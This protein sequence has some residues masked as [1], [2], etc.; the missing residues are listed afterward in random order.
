M[1]KHWIKRVNDY[2]IGNSQRIRQKYLSFLV[3]PLKAI[4]VKANH[5]T[6]LVFVTGLIAVWFAFDNHK[7]FILFGV[8]HILFDLLDGVLARATKPTINGH[9]LDQI[10]DHSIATLL[11]AKTFLVGDALAGI[12]TV[13]YAAHVSIYFIKRCKGPVIFMRGVLF[14]FYFVGYIKAGVILVA[15]TTMFG[16]IQQIYHFTFFKPKR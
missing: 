11:L 9:Y 8:L 5:I 3:S 7:Y 4:G 14:A 13:L 10:A 16:L 15:V 1:K 6:Y 2:M 12:V